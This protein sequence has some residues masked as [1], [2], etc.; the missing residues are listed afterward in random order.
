MIFDHFAHLGQTQREKRA[1][2]NFGLPAELR[3]DVGF[4]NLPMTAWTG[5]EVSFKLTTPW[6]RLG[7]G[8]YLCACHMSA[9]MA[10]NS[11]ENI[12]ANPF[13]PL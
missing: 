11:V 9:K 10:W 13:K 1:V 6:T 2:A 4:E 12:E 8:H 5:L 3:L 7:D